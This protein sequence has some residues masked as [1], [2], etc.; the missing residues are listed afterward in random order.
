[1]PKTFF[2][3]KKFD[4]KFPIIKKQ[5]KGS[6]SDNMEIIENKNQLKNFNPTK[7]MLQ[8]FIVGDEYGV[9]I[10]NDFSG[11]FVHC[12]IKKISMRAGETDKAK[13]VN[14]KKIFYLSKVA[15]N[16]LNTLGLLMWT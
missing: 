15:S 13:I 7:Q 12:C 2:N 16:F 11:K 8:K 14:S 3:L 5:V 6:A 4:N 1:M 10:L 9:D